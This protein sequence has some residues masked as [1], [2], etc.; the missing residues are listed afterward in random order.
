MKRQPP[1]VMTVTEFRKEKKQGNENLKPSE[2][3]I[4]LNEPFT[5]N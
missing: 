3:P 5:W 1:R 2:E 4:V